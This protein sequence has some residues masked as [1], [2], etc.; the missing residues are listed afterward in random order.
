M[1]HREPL[2]GS[3]ATGI[4]QDTFWFWQWLEEVGARSP[5]E[6]IA[7]TKR[8]GT[9]AY[10]KDKANAAIEADTTA[11]NPQSIL[12]GTG[13]D[14]TGQ[15]ACQHYECR[16]M[17]VDQLFRQAWFYFDRI[18]VADFISPLFAHLENR[19]RRR[20]ATIDP[21]THALEVLFYIKSLEAEDLISFQVKNHW[22]YCE[23][24]LTERLSH[25]GLDGIL[26]QKEAFIQK[27]EPHVEV[28]KEPRS[29]GKL[30]LI[31][32]HPLLEHIA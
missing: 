31:V 8:H 18:V 14:L 27:I 12:A 15:F 20:G 11:A 23:L 7:A 19:R 17:Q 9:L 32:S 3:P 22:R 6:A 1:C 10:L 4:M 26:D 30:N 28:H 13:I 16:I 2:R 5:Q 29:T 24:H 21:L 25:A